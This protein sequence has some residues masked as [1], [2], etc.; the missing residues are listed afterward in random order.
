[1]EDGGYS[2]SGRERWAQLRPRRVQLYDVYLYGMMQMQTEQNVCRSNA[3]VDAE[4]PLI[5]SQRDR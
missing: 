1:M 2:G 4:V 5:K 3:N